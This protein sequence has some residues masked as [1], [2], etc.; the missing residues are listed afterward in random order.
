[1]KNDSFNTPLTGDRELI[2]KKKDLAREFDDL[3]RIGVMPPPRCSLAITAIQ[4]AESIGE[5]KKIRSMYHPLI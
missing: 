3:R 1:M 2:N 4:Y 5:L